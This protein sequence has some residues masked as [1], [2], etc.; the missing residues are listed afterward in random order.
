MPELES[1]ACTASQGRQFCRLRLSF[2]TSAA[3][4][5]IRSMIS[6]STV[7]RCQET[8]FDQDTADMA[9]GRIRYY[10]VEVERESPALYSSSAGPDPHHQPN[11]VLISIPFEG[12]AANMNRA[13]RSEPD[14]FLTQL[15]TGTPFVA[16]FAAV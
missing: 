1:I 5:P 16:F 4:H 11:R 13:N 3:G 12:S 8:V 14:S 7:N 15:R 9:W 10:G 6:R 2:Q